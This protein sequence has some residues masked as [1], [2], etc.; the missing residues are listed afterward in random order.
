MCQHGMNILGSMDLLQQLQLLGRGRQPGLAWNW[1]SIYGSGRSRRGTRSAPARCSIMS[2]I[3]S[4]RMQLPLKNWACIMRGIRICYR[5]GRHLLL[6]KT[7][8]GL[9]GGSGELH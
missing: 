7:A 9:G 6:G 5:A 1:E 3:K 4:I 2:V 8:C